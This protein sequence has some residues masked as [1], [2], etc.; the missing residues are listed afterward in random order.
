ML[1]VNFE[2]MYSMS[3]DLVASRL[4]SP[5]NYSACVMDEPNYWCFSAEHLLHMELACVFFP[6]R[7]EHV[8]P[9]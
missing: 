3:C 4:K 5:L 6:S 2:T 1:H 8:S 9:C 7:V